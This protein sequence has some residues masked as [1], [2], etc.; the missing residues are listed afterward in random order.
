MTPSYLDLEQTPIYA[1]GR[2]LSERDKVNGKRTALSKYILDSTRT[3]AGTDFCA[4]FGRAPTRGDVLRF[5]DVRLIF[6]P[7]LHLIYLKR[8]IDA[9]VRQLTMTCPLKVENGR[10]FRRIIG[11]LRVDPPTWEEEMPRRDYAVRWRAIERE[12]G[13]EG[14]LGVVF[15]DEGRCRPA[16]EG[17]LAGPPVKSDKGIVGILLKVAG[18]ALKVAGSD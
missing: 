3:T 1:R 8:F 4:A 6:G 17:E 10:V 2:E 18:T 12:A 14:I 5:D 16:T 13:R 11:R 9:W 7:E 15:E